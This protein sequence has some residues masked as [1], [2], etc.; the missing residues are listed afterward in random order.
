MQ[1]FKGVVAAIVVLWCGPV[2]AADLPRYAAPAEWVKPAQIP[3]SSGAS[4]G[5]IEILLLDAQSR[6]GTE[7]D[8]FFAET[9]TKVVTPQGLASAGSIALSWDPAT[10]TLTLHRVAIIR[11]DRT[12]DLLDGGRNVTVLRRETQLE[13]SMLDG[14]LTAT[15]QPQGLQVGDIIDIA[16]TLERRDPVFQGRSQVMSYLRYPG[17]A[18]RVRIRAVWPSS[19]PMTWRGAPGLPQPIMS[20]AGDTEELLIDAKDFTA[21]IPPRHAPSRFGDVG[22]L[23]VSQFRD[24]SEV[25]GLMAPLYA[26]AAA[27]LPDSPLHAEAA[28]IRAASNDPKVRAEAALRLVQDKVHYV[29]LG[30][31]SGGYV[32][33][34]ADV[35][36][37]RRFGDCKGKTTLL[38]AI[39]RELGVEAQPALVNTAQG[40]GLDQRLPVV[41][42][43]HVIVRA[44]IKGKIYWLD[45]TRTG[46]RDL[47][48]IPVP[49]F[50]WALPVQPQDARLETLQPKPFDL[51]AFESLKEIDASAGYDTVAKA[52]AAHIFR[53]D[54]AIAW[55]AIFTAL[56]GADRDRRLKE[57]WRGQMPWLDP[58][59][60]SATYDDRRH[61]MRLTAAGEGKLDWTRNGD[62]RDYDIG[63]SN[64]GFTSSFKREPGPN[65]DAPISVPFPSSSKWVVTIRLPGNGGGFHLR[66]PLNLDTTVAGRH[67]V[68]RSKIEGPLVTMQAQEDSIASEFPYAEGE[69][70]SATLRQLASL[71][72]YVRGDGGRATQALP[73]DDDDLVTKPTSAEGF[74]HR[75]MVFMNR[76]D[77]DHAIADFSA[78]AA[79]EPNEGKHRYNTGAARFAKHDDVGALPD[80]DEAIRLNPKDSLAYAARAELMLAKG[81]ARRGWSDYETAVK[82]APSD[83]RLIER[84]A[85]ALERAGRYGE[86]VRDLDVLL[87]RSPPNQRLSLLNTRCWVRAEWGQELSSAQS[88]CEAALAMSPGLAAVLDSNGFLALRMGQYDKAIT[89]YDLALRQAPDLAPSLFGR[90]LAKYRKGEKA[91]ARA[92]LA[93]ARAL[94]PSIDAEFA[95]WGETA[96]R[97]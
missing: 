70:A 47:D 51:P 62:V 28:K 30:M 22:L 75:G 2:A 91:A 8:E 17:R 1:M 76:H 34:G 18:G 9:A 80:F 90:G 72:V 77:Y 79:L 20:R 5:A 10:E 50:H 64:L 67:F 88:D 25:S 66:G 94:H 59:T 89:N 65:E 3:T 31:N 56:D 29:F 96:P 43:D 48:D 68:R 49:D 42:F 39:L 23:Q 24:W 38:L 81:D 16:V 21:P 58:K 54:V 52:Q 12:I 45:G 4:G 83:L 41:S 46:D 33:A 92:D 86:A 6:L 87:A 95:R 37:S 26:K 73:A 19:K 78:A 93:A 15:V 32:P 11:D 60:V 82:L 13:L 7:S 35:T 69:A 55:N 74:S 85:V 71:N 44:A 40:D 36:W 84:R 63:D 57:Y 14:R 61:V 27:L 97:P 53:G